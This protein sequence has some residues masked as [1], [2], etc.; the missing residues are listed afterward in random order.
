MSTPQP[1]LEAL[2]LSPEQL[3]SYIDLGPYVNPSYYVVQEDE[4]LAKVHTLF[5]AMGPRH[6]FV[7]PR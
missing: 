4:S 6:V 5:R 2:G 7:I 1:P 3:D